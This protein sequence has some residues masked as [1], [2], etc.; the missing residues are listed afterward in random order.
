MGNQGTLTLPNEVLL[1]ILLHLAQLSPL[2]VR[3][4]AQVCQHWQAVLQTYEGLLWKVAALCRFPTIYSSQSW[5]RI[6]LRNNGPNHCG[7]MSTGSEVGSLQSWKYL[8]RLHHAW[9]NQS[10]QTLVVSPPSVSNAESHHAAAAQYSVTQG[11]HH[12]S[13]HHHDHHMQGLIAGQYSET[14]AEGSPRPPVLDPSLIHPSSKDHAIPSV[15]NNPQKLIGMADT[16]AVDWI[17][18]LSCSSCTYADVC[19]IPQA[20]ICVKAQR[21]RSLPL[22]QVVNAESL[23]QIVNLDDPVSTHQDL[24]SGLAVND[25]GTLLVSCSIDSTIRVWEIQDVFSLQGRSSEESF[26]D[27]VQRYGCPIQNRNV[28]MGHVGWVNGKE[29]LSIDAC[30]L[31]LSVLVHDLITHIPS[32][33]VAIENT[34]VVSGGSDHTVRVWD[35]LSGSQIRVIPNLFLSRELGLGVYT[36]AIHGSTIG[37]GSII[38]GYQV[39]DI[40]SGDLLFE[41]DEP[42]SSKD[43]FRFETQLYQ[44]YAARI[45]FT[46][47]VVV[48]NSKLEG[49]LCVWNR[50]NGQLLY[51]IQVCPPNSNIQGTDKTLHTIQGLDRMMVLD[52]YGST[53]ITTNGRSTVHTFKINKSGSMLMC[54]LCDGRVSLFEFGAVVRGGA[55]GLWIVQSKKPPITRQTQEQQPHRCNGQTAWIWIRSTFENTVVAL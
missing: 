26:R 7:K 4:L 21:D 34:T 41:I 31:F 42:L 49:V 1:D 16:R 48:T 40:Y 15:R 11:H 35:A 37:C 52:P 54:T 32:I 50:Q 8:F 2:S 29:N 22:M 9:A 10:G 39:H 20:G 14:R 51:R 23:D 44:Q 47:T 3:R 18:S 30:S 6:P 12:H 13:G 5:D 19:L 36:V 17:D 55:T 27:L 28:L 24:I 43:H 53:E 46:D 33:A 38:E 25:E 45:A